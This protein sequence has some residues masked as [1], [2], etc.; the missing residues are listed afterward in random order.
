M[1]LKEFDTIRL[2]PKYQGTLG[3]QDKIAQDAQRT[4]G[5]DEVAQY[6]VDSVIAENR[7]PM[8]MT[9]LAD[10]TGYSRQHVSNVILE[11]FEGLSEEGAQEVENA[12]NDLQEQLAE[13]QSQTA[14]TDNP[15]E[16]IFVEIDGSFQEVQIDVP[17]DVDRGSYVRGFLDG[18]KD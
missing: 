17:D 6:V 1:P 9:D 15:P 3:R 8:N 10:E 4:P 2:K 14:V 13:T 16:S 7:W 5:K 18:K 11:Y 12:T